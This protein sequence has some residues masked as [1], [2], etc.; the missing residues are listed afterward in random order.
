MQQ[1]AINYTPELTEKLLNLFEQYGPERIDEIANEI[2]KPRKSVIAK[3][4]RLNKYKAPEKPASKRAGLSK[5]ELLNEIETIVCFDVTGFTGA[6]KPAL[7][8]L[9]N[10]LKS[11]IK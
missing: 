2:S 10:Y 8:N 7:Q 6:S 5:K 9:L 11:S 1:K 3:L 4:V